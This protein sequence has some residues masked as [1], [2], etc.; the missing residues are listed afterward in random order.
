MAGKNILS[1]SYLQEYYETQG[2]E[3]SL[4]T[5]YNC[6]LPGRRF[7]FQERSKIILSLLE[8][9]KDSRFLDIGTGVGYYALQSAIRNPHGTNISIDISRSYIKQAKKLLK[10]KTHGKGKILFK[11]ADAR[12]LPF[13]DCYFDKILCTE[14][15][16]HVPDYKKIIEEISRVSKT[17]ADILITFPSKYGFDEIIGQLKGRINFYEHVNWISR[18]RFETLCR[19]NN[20]KI[21]ETQYCCFCFQILS[22]LI[23]SSPILLPVIE[24]IE[25]SIRDFPV[26]RKL[27]WHQVFLLKKI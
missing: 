1:E 19:H 14:V 5:T 2:K 27:C 17:G 4:S 23:D 24:K 21:E 9:K 10:N 8:F 20:L 15:I 18:E 7:Y 13:P 26:L 12:A 25:Y 6:N 16:E 3:S 11:L 22:R